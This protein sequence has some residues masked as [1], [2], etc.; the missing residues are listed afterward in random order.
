M[1]ASGGSFSKTFGSITFEL[2][3]AI[4][5][6]QLREKMRISLTLTS[7]NVLKD[8]LRFTESMF[9]PI[10]SGQLL[11]TSQL[12][13]SEWVQSSNVQNKGVLENF[14]FVARP[15]SKRFSSVWEDYKIGLDEEWEECLT[16]H[17][18][19]LVPLFVRKL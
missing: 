1:A 4:Q 6:T 2:S 11:E 16:S 19:F 15:P 13:T 17:L 14:P 10:T 3:V 5:H 7:R 18:P 8:F 12:H 9:N